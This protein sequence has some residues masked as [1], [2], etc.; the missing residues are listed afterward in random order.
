MFCR[1]E[2]ASNTLGIYTG[3][4]YNLARGT[5]N[6]QNIRVNIVAVGW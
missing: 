5:I 2:G 4:A 1:A 3:K 6:S